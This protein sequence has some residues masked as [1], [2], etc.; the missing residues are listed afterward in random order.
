MKT[1]TR[2]ILHIDDDADDQQL[3]RIAINSI[4][5]DSEIIEAGDGAEGIAQLNIMK[6]KNDL[7]C[8]IVL[9]INMPKINGR[10]A[11]LQIKKDT[12][13]AHIPMIIFSTS[14]SKLNKL[15]FEDKNVE[16]ITKPTDFDVL[17]S[18]ATKML[19]HCE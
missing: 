4:D 2:K 3:L 1:A 14:N 9:D 16:Y 19:G 13:L 5:G 18:I 11:C 7:P 6:E 12:V 10:D 15:F 8:L 17:V